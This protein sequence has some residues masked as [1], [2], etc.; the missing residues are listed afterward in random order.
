MLGSP[1]ILGELSALG[2][3][4]SLFIVICASE[5]LNE[6]YAR[7]GA[8]QFVFVAFS[9]PGAPF[10]AVRDVIRMRILRMPA[11]LRSEQTSISCALVRRR[12]ATI[13]CSLGCHFP[14]LRGFVAFSFTPG[15]SPCFAS[16]E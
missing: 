1:P 2:F 7:L 14:P 3:A 16:A 10:W 8:H 9:F 11:G 15:L 5:A 13:H 4:V 12:C 6:G